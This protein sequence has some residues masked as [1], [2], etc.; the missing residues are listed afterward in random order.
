MDI[1]VIKRG[2]NSMSAF[3]QAHLRKIRISPRKLNSV[4]KLIRR[5]S[6]SDAVSLLNGVKKSC[7]ID[8]LKAVK[9][10][11]SNA[12]NNMGLDRGRLFVSEASV[13]R[14]IVLRRLDIKGRS[15][16][17][18]ISKPFSNLRIVLSLGDNEAG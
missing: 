18:R 6:F 3:V 17:G 7:A 15:R 1:L 8:V 14:S 10:A 5:K 4:A 12:E 11:A 2:K 13:G 9:S 16:S